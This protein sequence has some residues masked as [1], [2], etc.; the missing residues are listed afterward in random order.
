LFFFAIQA[1]EIT[2]R[3]CFFRNHNIFSACD[4]FSQKI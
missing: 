1:R 2:P 3:K 4:L